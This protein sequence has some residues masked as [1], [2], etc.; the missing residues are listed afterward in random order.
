LSELGYGD[1]THTRLLALR[2]Q[3]ISPEYIQSLSRLGYSG[4]STGRLIALQA[5]GVSAE[6]VRELRAAGLEQD[7]LPVGALLALRAQGVTGEF[8]REMKGAGYEVSGPEQLIELRA[9]GARAP[10]LKR[11]RVRLST[12]GHP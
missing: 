2:A 10:L 6:Y 12:G 4:L 5:Q 8:V 11:L 1:L 3:G 7:Q 9:R